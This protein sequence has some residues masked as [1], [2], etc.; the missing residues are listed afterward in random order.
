ML[1]K[2]H[3]EEGSPPPTRGTLA[4]PHRI[5][6]LVRITPAYAGNTNDEKSFRLVTWDHPRLRGE[7]TV[8]LPNWADR[9]GSPPPT[10][11]TQSISNCI[12]IKFRITPAYAGNTDGNGYARIDGQDHPRLRG[13]HSM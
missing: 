9:I 12:I 7:H 3:S 1:G 11:G 8:K 13:E 10:R 4:H 5:Y 6:Y 2:H